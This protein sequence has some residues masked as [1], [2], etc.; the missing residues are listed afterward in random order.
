MDL[1]NTYVCNNLTELEEVLMIRNKNGLNMFI[2]GKE[3]DPYPC[4]NILVNNDWANVNYFQTCNSAGFQCVNSCKPKRQGVTIFC[5][6]SELQECS[7][8]YVIP[9]S[10][11]LKAAKEFYETM[12]KPICLKWF[13]L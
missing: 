1:E 7:N 2:V 4:L 12:T 9:F 11:A 10:H 5:I 8:E 13:E 3:N 6:G